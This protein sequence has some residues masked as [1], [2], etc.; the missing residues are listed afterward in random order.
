MTHSGV[1]YIFQRR[2][3]PQTSWARGNVLPPLPFLQCS[4]PSRRTCIGLQYAAQRWPGFNGK[5]RCRVTF[6][7]CI[8]GWPHATKFWTGQCSCQ[9]T[10]VRHSIIA[11]LVRRSDGAAKPE[12]LQAALSVRWL[13]LITIGADFSVFSACKLRHNLGPKRFQL[14]F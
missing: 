10:R 8:R 13:W 9:S 12:L 5:F 3:G 1:L 2:W 7:C 6:V 4:L 14:S 11:R